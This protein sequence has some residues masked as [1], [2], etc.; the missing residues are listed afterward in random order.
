MRQYLIS[1]LLGINVMLFI[2]N[3]LILNPP[4]ILISG[5]TIFAMLALG[6]LDA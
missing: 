2:F 6:A 5:L 3:I 1:F 4:G